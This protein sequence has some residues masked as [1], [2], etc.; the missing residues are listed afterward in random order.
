MHKTSIDLPSNTRTSVIQVLN[1]RL[2]D[3]T[4]LKLAVKHAHWN[5]KGP[6][7]I[8]LHKMFDEFSAELDTH[9]DAVAERVTALGGT[10]QGTLAETV[11]ASSQPAFPTDVVDGMKVV[12]AVAEGYAA[13]AKKVRDG[14][15]EADEA[16]DAG[17]ADLLTD[18]SRV[19][20]ERLWFLEAHL[21]A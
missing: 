11:K 17:T 15:D 9:I 18:V 4:D 2:A 8:G 19:L 1:S 13:A 21:Q 3:L 5:V 10:A 12:R 14:I 6:S 7:F 16:G 20:D